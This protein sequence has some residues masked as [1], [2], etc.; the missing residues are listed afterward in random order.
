MLE[1]AKMFCKVTTFLL[2]AA[3][4]TNGQVYKKVGIVDTEAKRKM[5][6][7]HVK[8][9][10]TT[11]E[12]NEEGEYISYFGGGSLLNDKW[13]LTCAHIFSFDEKKITVFAIKNMEYEYNE[14]AGQLQAYHPESWD[15]STLEN[16]IALVKLK[17]S[18][19]LDHLSHVSLPQQV[20][21]K[22]ADIAV[23]TKFQFCGNGKTETK[24]E[25]HELYYG[26]SYVLKF[27]RCN[28]MKNVSK[29]YQDE[30]KQICA[31]Q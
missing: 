21:G 23:G 16:D 7:Y 29:E 20:N 17:K 26:E 11:K 22:Y 19:N 6:S 14:R 4:S 30:R 31:G 25:T 12:K 1:L 27:T 15:A 28:N 2:L 13:V 24:N 18:F 9:L 5:F 10:A 8:I 3:L